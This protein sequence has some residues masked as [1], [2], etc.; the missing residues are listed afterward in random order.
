MTGVQT[1]ALPIC[2]NPTLQLAARVSRVLG[3]LTIVGIGGGALPVN[4]GSPKHE[5]SVA[6]PFW[7]SI[8]TDVLSELRQQSEQRSIRIGSLGPCTRTL[9]GQSWLRAA[10][11]TETERIAVFQ[12][13]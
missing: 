9:E 8:L 3:H 11:R 7:G 1:C 13:L 12:S 5:C 6:S 4:F 10:E 2:V